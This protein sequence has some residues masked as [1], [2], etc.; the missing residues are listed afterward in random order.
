ML[1]AQPLG[2]AGR[3]QGIGK[4]QEALNQPGLVGGQHGGL[5]PAI[6]LPA[7]DDPA[8]DDGA[9]RGNSAAQSGTVGGGIRR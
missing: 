4:Q 3:V 1:G 5:A 6:G 9:Q 2:F 7:E 8:G